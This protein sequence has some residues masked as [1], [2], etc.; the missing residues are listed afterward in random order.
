M[1]SV[2]CQL[3]YHWSSQQNVVIHTG[4]DLNTNICPRSASVYISLLGVSGCTDTSVNVSED[5]HNTNQANQNQKKPESTSNKTEEVIFNAFMRNKNPYFKI[6][7]IF[8]I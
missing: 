1:K 6:T 2:T 8:I 5:I 4:E 3:A 7:N